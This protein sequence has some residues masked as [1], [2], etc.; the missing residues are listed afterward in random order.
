M[1]NVDK[2][3]VLGNPVEHSQSPTIHLQFAKQT[4]QHIDYEKICVPQDDFTN[5]VKRLVADG[6]RGFNITLPFKQQAYQ[7]VDQLTQRAKHAK[8]VNTIKVLDDKTLLGDNTD[9]VGLI[10][11]LQQHH[12]TLNQKNVLLLGASG[13]ARGILYPLL[14]QSP[15]LIHIANRSPDKANR[16]AKEFSAFGT[17]S[18]SD[19]SSIP[20]QTFDVILNATSAS[21]EGQVPAIANSLIGAESVCY[22]LYY[23]QGLTSFLRWCQQQGAKTLIDG[24]GMLIQQAAESFYVWRGVKVS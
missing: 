14:Q 8:A 24:H 18:S 10:T 12:I 19:L 22:D 2:Y 17:V 7:L 15:A 20:S 3:A 9:G 6:Y 11:D 16:L 23:Q 21:V 1:T 5:T 13:A 4:Q